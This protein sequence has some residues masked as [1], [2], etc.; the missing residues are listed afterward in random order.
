[1]VSDYLENFSHSEAATSLG[2]WLE[3]QGVAGLSGVDTRELTRAL[4]SRGTMLGRIAIGG[5]AAGVTADTGPHGGHALRD[6]NAT[7]LVREVTSPAVVADPRPGV[8]LA[9][10]EDAPHIVVIDCGCKR[11]ILRALR[12][13]GCRLTVVPYDF[14]FSAIACDGVLLSNGPGDPALC[15]ATV[16]HTAGFLARAG[17]ATAAGGGGLRAGPAPPVIP[18]AGI[19]LGNQ[20]LA[21]AAGARTYK[22]PYGHRGQNQP[23]REAGTERCRITSQNHGYAVDAG[24]LPDGWR[25]WFTNLNDGTVEGIR[26]VSLPYFAVQFH[27]EGAPGPLDSL[28]FFDEFVAAAR[29]AMRPGIRTGGTSPWVSE[30]PAK[31]CSSAAADCASDRPG[32]SI[33]PDPRL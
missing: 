15:A 20:L 27:P 30:S 33:T 28:D 5:R 2:R 32:S 26:H 6:P 16:R 9:R 21:L 29:R 7:D 11:S 14:E 23:V 18:V 24:T 1:V 17:Q 22:L 3:A 31:S 4:R 10:G 12:E 25:V 19:C 8:P 13:R